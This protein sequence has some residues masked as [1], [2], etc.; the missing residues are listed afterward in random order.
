MIDAVKDALQ[1][2]GVPEPALQSWTGKPLLVLLPGNGAERR[3]RVRLNDKEVFPIDNEFHVLSTLKANELDFIVG[4]R[5]TRVARG[6][7]REIWFETVEKESTRKYYAVIRCKCG[8]RNTWLTRPVAETSATV[9]CADCGEQE[10]LDLTTA[11]CSWIQRI[12]AAER[13][14]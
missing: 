1:V 6:G 4:E 2:A 12:I 5:T 3:W 8:T 7:L 10:A 13:A 14:E 9:T 11:Q